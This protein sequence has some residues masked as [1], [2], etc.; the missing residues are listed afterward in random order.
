MN[1]ELNSLEDMKKTL[2]GLGFTSGTALL[3][4]KFVLTEVPFEE[5]IVTF[6]E[7]SGSGAGA[8]G[9]EG[10]ASTSASAAASAAGTEPPTPSTEENLIDFSEDVPMGEASTSTATPSITA[11]TNDT[12]QDTPSE[13]PSASSSSTPPAQPE[14]G[15][16]SRPTKIFNPGTASS[17]PPLAT[18]VEVDPKDYEMNITQARQYQAQLKAAT[19][20]KRLLTED[21]KRKIAEEEKLK[22]LAVEKV[23]VRFR[24]PEGS[25]VQS[26]FLQ[27]DTAA[28]LYTFVRGMMRHSKEEFSLGMF[29]QSFFKAGGNL[30]VEKGM[31]MIFYLTALP[32]PKH[33]PIP[34]D[35][36][37]IIVG[38]G[39]L[40]PTLLNF[41]WKETTSNN[42]KK[43][44]PLSDEYREKARKMEVPQEPQATVVDEEVAVKKGSGSGGGGGS[45]SGGG[46]GGKVPK[47]LK[48][49]KK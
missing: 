16:Q 10:E 30:L 37:L 32:G 43:S 49:G 47:W 39:I 40:A 17:K 19:I 44:D 20:N 2:A 36:T 38:L 34:A 42:I 3:R 8:G 14:L 35:D 13:D 31:L 33:T 24:F 6:A 15:P 29:I 7:L 46:V 11:T 22:R 28:D 26:V 18:T 9:E 48:F 12:T 5:A 27:G 25:V 21:Q 41:Y 23:D 4:V 45:S 1:K